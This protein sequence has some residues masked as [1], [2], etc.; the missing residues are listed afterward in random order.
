MD[1]ATVTYDGKLLGCQ[2]LGDFYTDVLKLGFAKAW[3]EWPYSVRLPK[4]NSEC[5]ACPHANICQICPAVRM[6]ECNNLTD[7][8]EYICKI[9][10]Q[11]ALRN[12][13]N[14]L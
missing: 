3:E 4:L 2:M 6:A 13:E 14:L 7:K 1:N 5:A 10:K 11:Y 12:G 9:T 8:P